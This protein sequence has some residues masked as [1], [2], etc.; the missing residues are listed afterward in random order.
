MR[1]LFPR[2]RRL[3][4]ALTAVLPTVGSGAY[5]APQDPARTDGGF[6]YD[7]AAI[8]APRPRPRQAQPS[9]PVAARGDAPTRIPAERYEQAYGDSRILDRFRTRAAVAGLTMPDA[10]M[11]MPAIDPR[12]LRQGSDGFARTLRPAL[13]RLRRDIDAELRRGQR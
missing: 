7:P 5:A 3:I 12:T 1:S 10:G 8:D 2:R 9:A 13:Q 11:T 6:A 4:A